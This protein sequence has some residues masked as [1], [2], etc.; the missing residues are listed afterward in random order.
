MTLTDLLSQ[1]LP[2]LATLRETWL[3]FDAALLTDF[4]AAQ[5]GQTRFLAAPIALTDGRYALCADLLT[6]IGEMG[7]YGKSFAKLPAERFNEV[8][9][10]EF[11]DIAGI[12]PQPPIH[13]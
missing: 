4:N 10:V 12:L 11:A 3:V 8:T 7:V 2:D 13:E 6:E 9:V 5:T 1:P